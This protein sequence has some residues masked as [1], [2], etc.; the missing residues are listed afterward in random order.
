MSSYVHGSRFSY[1]DYL[2]AKSFEQGLRS[3]ISKQTRALIATNEQLQREHISVTRSLSAT[4]S[5][6]FEQLS[7]DLQ[8]VRQDL[9]EINST[10]NWGFSELL[11]AVGRVNDSLNDL[12]KISKTPAQIWAYEQFEIAREAYRKELYDEAIEQLDRAI[13]GHGSNAGYKL[14]YRFHYLLGTIQLGSFRNNSP[15]IVNLAQAESAFL[16]A[17]RYARMDE[18]MEAGRAFLAA[19]WSA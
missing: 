4:V 15:E 8:G 18:P 7:F 13:G 5:D 6:G 9:A 12:I 19:G 1:L 17:A 11:T 3:E 14:E 10:L 16:N 2:Q